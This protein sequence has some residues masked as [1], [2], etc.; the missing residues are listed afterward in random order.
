M[1]VL[2]VPWR[3]LLLSCCVRVALFVRSLLVRA[4][5]PAPPAFSFV[6]QRHACT[7]PPTKA[8][9]VSCVA[10]FQKVRILAAMC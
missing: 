3:W 8:R 6:T 4:V 9:F 5:L 10:S 1:W 2:V 7:S